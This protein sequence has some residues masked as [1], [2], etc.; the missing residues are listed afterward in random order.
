MTPATDR[1]PADLEPLRQQCIELD[2]RLCNRK[3]S[4]SGVCISDQEADVALLRQ[5]QALTAEYCRAARAMGAT[6]IYLNDLRA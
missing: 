4:I 2:R 3:P 1:L 5:W 6:E